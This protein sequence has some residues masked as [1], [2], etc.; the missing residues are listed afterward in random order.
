MA[1]AG[2]ILVVI[3]ARGGSKRLPRKNM[4]PL[5]GKPLIC[6]TIEAALEAKLNARIM[7]TSDDEEILA[8][9]WQYK[10]EGV[11]AYK[12]PAELATD[13]A[14]TADVLIDAVKAEQASGYD[15]KTLV[16]LQPTSPLRTA[17]DIPAALEVFREGGC[18]DTVVTVCEVDHPT[19][20]VG[21]IGE[22]SKL[23]GIDLSG[24]R[25]QDYRKEYRLNGA[26][27]VARTDHLLNS[28]SLFTEGVRASV[29]PR[30]RSLDIDESVDFRVCEGL[31]GSFDG[32]PVPEP[33]NQ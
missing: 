22:G 23:E 14:S 18:E 31:I 21:T 29:M 26:V 11:I 32:H 30:V 12:R 27:Y 17:D 33:E 16:L 13:A 3:P 6:W 25:S 24:K 1:D 15:P 4:L 28:G 9:A 2:D 7:V 19:A 5:G 8:I 20:W 10:N